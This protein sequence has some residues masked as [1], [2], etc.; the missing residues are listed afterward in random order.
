MKIINR[1]TGDTIYE[2]EAKTM[3]D[4]VVAA[5]RNGVSLEGA[6]LEGADMRGANLRGANLQ[7]ADL[8]GLTCK[9]LICLGPICKGPIWKGSVLKGPIWLTHASLILAKGQMVISSIFIADWTSHI[10]WPGVDT[11]LLQMPGN[12]GARRVAELR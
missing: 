12:I 2:A 4:L 7:G 6:N 10:F 3:R 8:L 9:G 11:S 1:F 5:V